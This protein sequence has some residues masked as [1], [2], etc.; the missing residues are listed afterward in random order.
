VAGLRGRG[1]PVTVIPGV[2]SA[3][4]GPALAGLPLTHRELTQ[5]FTVISGHAP[6]GDPGSTLK[7]ASLATA[8]TTLVIMMGVATLPAKTAELIKYG[9]AADTPAMTVADAA[10][11][12]QRSVRGTLANIAALTKESG[13][14]PP[15]IT[16]IGLVAGFTP[17]CG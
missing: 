9:L 1:I 3:T 4:A 7:L 2:S 6:P 15:A 14:K 16:V 11:P 5:G 17:A 8:N 10:T 12:S 13:I